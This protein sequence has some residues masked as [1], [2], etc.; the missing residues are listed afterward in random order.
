MILF[1]RI[2]TRAGMLTAERTAIIQH[3]LISFQ[4]MSHDLCTDRDAKTSSD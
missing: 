2:A 3:K 4:F 1:S